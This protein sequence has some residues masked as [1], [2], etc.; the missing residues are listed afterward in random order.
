MRAS[1]AAVAVVC[2]ALVSVA[3]S[4]TKTAGAHD[5]FR[6]K[7]VQVI[8]Q[9]GFEKPIPAVDLLIPTDWKFESKVQWANRGCFTDVAA[10]SFRAQSPDGRLVIEAFPSF[11]WQFSQDQAVQKYRLM[12]NQA[13]AKPSAEASRC[14]F[15]LTPPGL[16][17]NTTYRGNLWK[18]GSP[19]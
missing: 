10:V 4:D 13:G 5:Y 19:R 7:H 12:E 18:S 16:V 14:S 11:S 15:A 8:D 6:M 2:A 3:E 17:S 9:S 1:S